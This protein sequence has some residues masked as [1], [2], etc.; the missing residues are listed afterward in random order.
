[1]IVISVIIFSVLFDFINFVHYFIK[2]A[3]INHKGRKVPV[4]DSVR[5]NNS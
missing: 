5:I 4:N 3:K 2:I 1:M